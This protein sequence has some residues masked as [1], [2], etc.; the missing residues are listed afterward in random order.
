MKNNIY[1]MYLDAVESENFKEA[2]TFYKKFLEETVVSLQ[3]YYQSQKESGFSF[4]EEQVKTFLTIALAE[5]TN[6]NVMQEYPLERKTDKK[7]GKY[8]HKTGRLDYWANFKNSD[9]LIEV[10]HGWIRYYP[11]F[12]KTT[13]YKRYNCLFQD[14]IKQVRS[15]KNKSGYKSSKHLF[16]L[17]LMVA[18]YFV[19]SL[20]KGSSTINFDRSF[21]NQLAQL[22]KDSKGNIG[23][24]WRLESKEIEKISYTERNKTYL[25]YYPGVLFLGKLVKYSRNRN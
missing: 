19:K 20:D 11:E 22:L 9:F 16:G 25:E 5:V 18:P 13:F 23:C 21:K 17:S 24:F 8:K 3:K 4:G 15:I 2:K 12:H 1:Y 10:K 7:K 6:H 14:A